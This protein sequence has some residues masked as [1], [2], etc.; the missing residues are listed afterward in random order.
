MYSKEAASHLRKEFWTSLGQYMRP[1]SS[2]WNPRVNWLN[3]H[4]GIKGIFLRMHADRSM[5]SIGVEIIYNDAEWRKGVFDAFVPLKML[6]HQ[7]LEEEWIWEAEA[8][9]EHGKALSRIYTVLPHI[10]VMRKE[11]WPDM[12]AFFKPRLIAFDAFW[13]DAREHLDWLNG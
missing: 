13:A 7:T 11:D 3:Y 5:A 9:D 12:I 1:I 6:L 2:A 10:N 4:T 8:F